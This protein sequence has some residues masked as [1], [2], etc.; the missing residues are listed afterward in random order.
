MIFD[1]LV[2]TTHAL[3]HPIHTLP[4]LSIGRL[5]GWASYLAI[6]SY[7]SL[8]VAMFWA[9]TNSS[10]HLE[11]AKSVYGLILAGAQVRTPLIE[12][13][14]QIMAPCRKEY[15]HT[16]TVV[17]TGRGH[18]GLHAG[19][20]RDLP[21][22]LAPLYAGWAHPVLHGAAGAQVY[23]RFR[24]HPAPRGAAEGCVDAYACMHVIDLGR[25]AGWLTDAGPICLYANNKP[26]AGGSVGKKKVAFDGLRTGT[27]APMHSSFNHNH[28]EW[29]PPY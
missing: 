14:C 5:L 29:L 15:V 20:P 8:T 19:H 3:I 21:E 22:P 26:I 12:R 1:L 9:F 17:H 10:V 13:D 23:T 16:L 25:F 11:G 4:S 6:E 24:A 18:R 27:L 7:G 2:Y 28:L